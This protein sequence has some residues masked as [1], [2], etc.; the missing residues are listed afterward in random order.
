MI[1]ELA[2]LVGAKSVFIESGAAHLETVKVSRVELLESTDECLHIKFSVYFVFADV[3][4]ANLDF[5]AKFGCLFFGFFNL[6]FSAFGKL[7]FCLAGG[8]TFWWTP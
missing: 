3:S 1:G 4:E 2:C 7:D 6:S 8:T 5:V